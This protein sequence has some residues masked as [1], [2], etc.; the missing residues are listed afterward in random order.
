MIETWNPCHP[1]S[2]L[3]V[4]MTPILCPLTI[5]TSPLPNSAKSAYL[6][7]S[8]TLILM[9]TRTKIHSYIVKN[10]DQLLFVTFKSIILSR[11]CLT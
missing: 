11:H 10:Y 2:P 9:E 4:A 7:H 6:S 5:L 3:H 8:V 1:L